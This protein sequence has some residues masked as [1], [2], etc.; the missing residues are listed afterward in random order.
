MSNRTLAD[1]ADE[2]EA[3][4][5]ILKMQIEKIDKELGSFCPGSRRNILTRKREI[6]E[7]MLMESTATMHQL[8]NYYNK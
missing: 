5:K 6:L 3:N 2:Y 7:D 4:N 8:R 1:L